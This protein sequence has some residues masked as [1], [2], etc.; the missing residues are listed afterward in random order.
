MIRLRLGIGLLAVAVLAG[1]NTMGPRTVP[2]ARLNYN[3][4]IA[5]SRDEQLLLNL[6]RLRYRDTPL[7]L[8]IS[9]VTTQYNL[10]YAAGVSP[11]F[12]SD[13]NYGASVSGSADFATTAASSV[14]RNIAQGASAAKNRG[15]SKSQNLQF[16]TGVG[17]YERPTVLYTPL[18]GQEFVKHMLVPLRLEAL[19]LLSQSGWSIQRVLRLCAQEM[20]GLENAVTA[21]GPTPTVAPEWRDFDRAAGLL[22]ELQLDHAVGLEMVRAQDAGPD[23]PVT[24]TLR[25]LE[26]V[27]RPMRTCANYASC[28]VLRRKRTNS[29]SCPT[30]SAR[31]PAKSAFGPARCWE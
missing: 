25:I 12:G 10:E 6:V 28:C 26:N 13:A 4:A 20:N 29:E 27:A 3:E 1:C 2:G 18:Q 15:T 16:D 11:S 31:N 21:A 5:R 17:Y 8:D 19:A 30:A 7:F 22:R 23:G 9:S 24:M 14:T